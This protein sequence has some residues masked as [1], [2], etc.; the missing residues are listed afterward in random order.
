MLAMF[1]MPGHLELL[2]IGLIGSMVIGVPIIIV[3]IAMWVS[4]SGLQSSPKPCP[5]C[6]MLAPE[7]GFCPHCGA[8]VDPA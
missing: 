1:G 6:G 2:I 7:H 8:P 4:R 3:F 5:K